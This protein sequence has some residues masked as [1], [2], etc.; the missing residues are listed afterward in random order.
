MTPLVEAFG[1]LS[2]D[3]QEAI[4]LEYLG[5]QMMTTLAFEMVEDEPFQETK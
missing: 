5:G 3:V 4:A 2:D 1:M